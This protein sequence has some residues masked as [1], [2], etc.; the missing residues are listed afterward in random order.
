MAQKL[1][2]RAAMAAETA[3]S[4]SRG[5]QT[6]IGASHAFLFIHIYTLDQEASSLPKETH[7]LAMVHF[8]TGMYCFFTNTVFWLC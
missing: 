8:E 5:K 6:L 4:N 3:G 2:V 7:D 1:L